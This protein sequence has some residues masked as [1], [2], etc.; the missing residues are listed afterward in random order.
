MIEMKIG[1]AARRL[2]SRP[3]E[4]QTSGRA[5]IQPEIPV[6]ATESGLQ[7][8]KKCHQGFLFI[9]LKP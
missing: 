6:T 3:S 8:Q 9:P 2:A 1:R 4:W 5:T 7:A